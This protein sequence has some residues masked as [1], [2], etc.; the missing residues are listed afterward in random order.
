MARTSTAKTESTSPLSRRVLVS[1]GGDITSALS[2]VIWQHEIPLLE[3][4]WG[5]GNVRELDPA[6][7]DDGY[8]AKISP[9]LLPHNKKQDHIEKPSETAGIGFVFVGDARQEYERLGSVYG[10]HTEHNL[11]YVEHVYGRFQTGNFQ[12]ML[13][14]ADFDDM[15]DAQL[16]QVAI[17]HG[18]LP[19]VSRDAT[20]E[21]RRAEAAAR[22]ALYAMP[23][24]PLLKLVTDLAAAIA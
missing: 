3:E 21:E 13:G 19:I 17:E 8:T 18:H 14:L 16:R 23:R 1:I 5:E 4:I 24:E 11:L 12:K 9:A 15:P 10:R 20:Q 6:L 7:L 22:A 2:K